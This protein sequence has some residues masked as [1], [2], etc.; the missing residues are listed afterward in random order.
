MKDN[1]GFMTLHTWFKDALIQKNGFIKVF[2][3]EAIE[4]K[5]ETYE[6]LTE[7]EY[8]SLLANDDVELISKT[9]N[10]MEE[11]IMDEMGN[12]QLT[13]QIFYDCE[14][15]RKKT[16]GKVQIENVPPEEMLIS[17]EAK[18]LQTADF[19]AH[20][21]TKTRSQLVREGFDRDIIM[22]LPAFDEQ[23]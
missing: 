20:R 6:N 16:V 14:V 5:K 2:W 13:Q 8:Q 3:N 7:I 1:P 19:I 12:P 9:E 4:E 21:V 17:R 18:D 23:V 22:G 10:I 11:E 15:K